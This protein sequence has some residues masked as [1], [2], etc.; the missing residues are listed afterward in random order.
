[1][2]IFNI[3]LFW[4]TI[5]PTY[6]WLMYAVGFIYAYYFVK[7]W[8]KLSISKMDDLLFFSFLWVVL[9]WRL[10]Y[11]LFYDLF[12]YLSNPLD[13]LKIWQ[14]GMSFHWGVIW[15]V[16][17]MFFFS[18]KYKVSFLNLADEVCLTLPVW[19]FLWRIWNY[20]NKEL[21]WFAN[22]KWPLAVY[23]DWIWYFPSPLLEATLE[24]IILFLILHF[25][26]LI[27]HKKLKFESSY[28]KKSKINDGQVAALFL[29]YY[30]LFR[31]FVEL[32]IRTPDVQI[33]YIFWV[34]T[35]WLILTLPMFFVWV[36]YFF[37]LR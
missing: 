24:W 23:K 25:F 22:Y 5:A 15:V 26:N 10:W 8:M 13:I 2:Y 21:L 9:W 3:N 7:K 16:L 12:Y 35:M 14:G 33:W 29:L 31:V 32:F 37:K 19:L 30:S 6:Y 36:Y 17:A 27:K 1:M 18:R 4:I 20:L 11:V 28:F 34:F